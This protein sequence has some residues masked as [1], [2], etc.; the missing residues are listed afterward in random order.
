[1]T[2]QQ[3]IRLIKEPKN[4]IASELRPLYH[5]NALK[6]LS[7]EGKKGPKEISYTK[8]SQLLITTNLYQIATV[9]DILLHMH[10]V[11]HINP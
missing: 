7:G 6:F 5:I 3:T 4:K 8:M 9:H 1:M 10:V 11:L 2:L